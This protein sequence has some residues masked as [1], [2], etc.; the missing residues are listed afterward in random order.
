[1]PG[2][3]PR[4]SVSQPQHNLMEM[5]AHGG[6]PTRVQGGGP[7]PAVAREFVQADKGKTFGPAQKARQL[8]QAAAL[9]RGG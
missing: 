6:Q 4:A 5:I 7:P 1:M 3:P 8:A 9:R 2:R